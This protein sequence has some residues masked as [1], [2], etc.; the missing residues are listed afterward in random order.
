LG[1]RCGI[2]SANVST[3]SSEITG[4]PQSPAPVRPDPRKSR[5]QTWWIVFLL[6]AVLGA[7][8][9]LL[10][11]VWF[12][13]PS[14]QDVETV[15]PADAV[16][17]FAGS[18]DRFDT[19]VEL[20]ESGAA[21]NLVLVNGNTLEGDSEDLC[22]TAPYQ[23]FCPDSRTIDTVGEAEAIGRLARE[24]GWSNL[25]AVTST[26]H[27]HRA[28]SL[29]GRCFDGSIQVVTPDQGMDREELIGKVPHEWAG[30]LASFVFGPS[31]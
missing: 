28:T 4:H 20:M 13:S 12:I 25:I 15:Q 14:T 23:V 29:L 3:E 24:Q 31:C 30:F 21:P 11:L 27:V 9:L 26:Y 22:E 1:R 18:S 6:A 8:G 19:A 5:R 16:V 17:L 2:V 10:T 7:V